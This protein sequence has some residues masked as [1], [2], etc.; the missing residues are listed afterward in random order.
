SIADATVIASS[1][2]STTATF[3]VDLTVPSG[4]PVTVNYATSDETAIAGVD[5]DSS[6]NSL[7]F[8]PG[9]TEQTVTVTVHPEPT[10]AAARTFAVNLF[11][12]GGA[13]IANAQ[14]T[15]T[16]ESPGTVPAISIIPTRVVSSAGGP[17]VAAFVVRLSAASTRPVTV[18]YATAGGTATAGVN[19][20]AV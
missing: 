2:D 18:N 5:Y 4:Q 12:P 20:V 6:G 7:T 3:T 13:T 11:G 15:G 16:I 10:G 14:A 9:Q 1:S 17:V 8:A 19:Y